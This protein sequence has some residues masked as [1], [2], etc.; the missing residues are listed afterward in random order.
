LSTS[1][2][3]LVTVLLPRVC[4]HDTKVHRSAYLTSRYSARKVCGSSLRGEN[5]GRQ[6]QGIFPI[7]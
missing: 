3:H 4:T 7:T 6:R 5:D 2:H 1:A